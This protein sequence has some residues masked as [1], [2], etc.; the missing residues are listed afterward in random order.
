MASIAKIEGKRGTYYRIRV[1]L[2][3]SPDGKK[4]SRSENYTPPLYDKSGQLRSDSA[5][6]K[7]VQR[8]AIRFEQE[9]KAA[10]G[11]E[12][13]SMKVSR[14]VESYLTNHAAVEL[15]PTTA[16]NYED[17]LRK[18]ILPRF[19]E[20]KVKDLCKR[21][22]EIQNFFSGLATGENPRKA[23]TIDKYIHIFS[24]VFSWAISM[25]VVSTNPLEHVKPPKEAFKEQEQKSFSVGEA[26]RFLQALNMSYTFPCKEHTAQTAHG[27][28]RIAEHE[29][30]REIPEQY[31]VFFTLALLTGCRRGELIALNW[32]DIDFEN[33]QIHI[34][35]N[36][37]NV[38]GELIIKDVKT[39]SG[40]RTVTV[41]PSVMELLH[42][43]KIHQMEL[44]LQLGTAWKGTGEA[45][46]I[47]GEGERMNLAAPTNRFK[48]IIHNYNEHCAPADR[49]PE[50]TLHGLRHTSASVL[51]AQGAD[52]ASVSKRLGHSKISITLDTYTHDVL[53][54]ADR[55]ASRILGEAFNLPETL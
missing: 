36:C 52:I 20:Y 12:D 5:L 33:C 43:W 24:A 48:S 50:I 45:V 37:G 32:S 16:K 23:S 18:V 19:G 2:G 28:V 31:R 27:P 13:S 7:D 25:G 3:Y 55:A 26:N 29:V 35:K 6:E 41:E 38:K 53:E 42:Q 1:S 44:R 8:E 22:I 14:L 11:P 54:D 9:C 15:A 51:V 10:D 34:T 4:I 39:R 17:V 40:R 47:G 30:T 49:L 46:F 21:T